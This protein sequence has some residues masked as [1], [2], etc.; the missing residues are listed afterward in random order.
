MTALGSK[1]SE[2]SKYH[3]MRGYKDY[4]RNASFPLNSISKFLL[5]M[6]VYRGFR[7]ILILL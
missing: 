5:E 7:I 4:S 2:F 6:T 1:I 3:V